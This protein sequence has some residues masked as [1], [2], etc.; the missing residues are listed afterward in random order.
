MGDIVSI[1]SGQSQLMAPDRGLDP[2]AA[3]FRIQGYERNDGSHAQFLTV[4][5]PQ[6]HAKLPGLSI[7]EAGSY[8]LTMGTIHRALY[9]T[10]AIE[11]GKR[12]FVEG[13]STGTGYDCL[14][15]ALSSSCAALGMVSSDSRGERVEAVGGRAIIEKTLDGLISSLQFLMTQRVGRM[16]SSR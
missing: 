9:N 15:S 11:P 14:R 13:A 10:L 5:G 6:L 16:G 4:Q 7:E 1:Y 2:M 12:L 8:G 3:D